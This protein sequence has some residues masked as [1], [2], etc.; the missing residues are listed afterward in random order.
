[1]IAGWRKNSPAKMIDLKMI[2]RKQ[3]RVFEGSKWS[4]ILVGSHCTNFVKHLDNSVPVHTLYPGPL[5]IP[6]VFWAF[7]ESPEV[8]PPTGLVRISFREFDNF[9]NTISL[10]FFWWGFFKQHLPVEIRSFPGS[11]I[12]PP[13]IFWYLLRWMLQLDLLRVASNLWAVQLQEN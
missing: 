7:L 1:M 13:N 9:R 5:R 12:H 6:V 2:A 3:N 11:F 8:A 10:R 4:V